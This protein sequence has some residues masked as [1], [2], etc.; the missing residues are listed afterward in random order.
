MIIQRLFSSKGK[1]EPTPENKT[2]KDLTKLITGTAS[3]AVLGGYA[4]KRIDSADKLTSIAVDLESHPLKQAKLMELAGGNK[5]LAKRA[6]QEAASLITPE[7]VRRVKRGAKI[8]AATGGILTGANVIRKRVQKDYSESLPEDWNEKDEKYIDLVERGKRKSEILTKNPDKT[9]NIVYA[10]VGAA[11][12][13]IS[14]YKRGR[15]YKRPLGKNLLGKSKFVDSHPE[16]VRSAGEAAKRGIIGL[17]L[18]E[19]GNEV[20]ELQS[21]GKISSNKTKKLGEKQRKDADNA[22]KKYKKMKSSKEREDY[23]KKIGVKF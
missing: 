20:T 2:R 12:G 21:G 4:G 6:I 23:R 1:K 5:K 3:G 22:I 10:G 11:S 14:G 18:S 19:L 9:R 15:L 8:G 17:S 7:T 16:I 13:L